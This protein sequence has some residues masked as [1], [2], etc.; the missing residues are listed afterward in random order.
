MWSDHRL[1]WARVN[2]HL[3]PKMRRVGAAPRKRY[4][5]QALKNTVVAVKFRERVTT[6]LNK[7]PAGDDDVEHSWSSIKNALTISADAELVPLKRKHQDWFH[8]ND[9]SVSQLPQRLRSSHA[10]WLSDRTSAAKK[11]EYL[12]CK[13]TAQAALRRMKDV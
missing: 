6:E 2:L 8:E 10:V 7:I 4:D 11:G 5:V 12:Q 9:V 3:K 13:R 1:L